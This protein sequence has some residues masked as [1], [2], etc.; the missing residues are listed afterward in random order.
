MGLR[1]VW[2]DR[3]LQERFEILDYYRRRNGSGGYSHELAR[4][5]RTSLRLASDQEL[6]GKSTDFDA[7][8]CLTVLDYALFYTTRGPDLVVLSVWDN[9]RNPD[10]RPYST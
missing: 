1:V 5:F 6:L 9:R 2:S 10:D 4:Y 3:A 8:R 7:V